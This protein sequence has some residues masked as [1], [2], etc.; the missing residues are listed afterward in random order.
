MG[1]EVVWI[2]IFTPY[3]GTVVYGFAAILG[4]YLLATFVGTKLYRRGVLAGRASDSV[5]W[6]FLGVAG[7]LPLISAHPLL[8]IARLLRLPLGVIPLA[9]AAGFAT[10]MLVDRESRGDPSR[11]GCVCH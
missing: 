1:M 8:A 2:R 10:P 3:L 4:V 11:A 6:L 5:I 7:L 9:T